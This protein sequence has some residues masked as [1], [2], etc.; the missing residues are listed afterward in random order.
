MAYSQAALAEKRKYDDVWQKP[1]Y[2]VKSHGIELWTRG[3]EF[4]PKFQSVV[5]LGCG[6][7]RY[8]SYMAENEGKDA[9]GV[10]FDKA[11]LDDEVREKHSAYFF[12][13]CLWDMELPVSFDMGVC[14]DV[15]EHIP[16]PYVVQTYQRIFEHCDKS[17]FKIAN[18][19]S[20]SLGHDLHPTMKAADWWLEKAIEAGGTDAKIMANGFP[21]PGSFI[22]TV[23]Y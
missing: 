12:E 16:E 20:K 2:R 5:D 10:D 3:R 11:Y 21:K 7:G 18:F 13:Q 14:T 1:E 22:I 15:M 8:F 6:H 19:S 17:I 9:F 23:G 4:F